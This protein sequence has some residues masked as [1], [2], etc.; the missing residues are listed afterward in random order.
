M[1]SQA[2]WT[3]AQDATTVTVDGH[4]LDLAYWEGGTEH[5]GP[6][7]VFLHG[8]PTWSFLW[9]EVA[10]TLAEERHVIAPDMLGYGNSD[11]ADRF[12]RSIRAQEHM[13]EAL[14]GDHD[15]VSF[16]GHD[17][18]GGAILRYAS[19]H[20]EAVEQLVLSNVVCYDSWPVEFVAELGLPQTADA[21][22]GELE[23]RFDVAFADGLAGDPADHADWV[24]G[25]AEPWRSAEGRTSLARCAVAT[26]TNHTTEIDYGAIT[27]DTLLLWAAA[28]RMQPVEYAHRL[29]EDI[30]GDTALTT[31]SDAYHWIVEDRTAAYREHLREFLA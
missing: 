5:D 10:P 7:V 22:P 2:E 18:G 20:P 17:I 28:D 1:V 29:A 19:H 27:A 21:D 31:L 16:V 23:A 24:A 25:V 15:A 6:P 8:I 12:D 3:D 11:M 13:L 9:R 14:L 26:N 30:A 4:D